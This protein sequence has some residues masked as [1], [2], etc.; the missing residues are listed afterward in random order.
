ML[1]LAAIGWRLCVIIRADL[2]MTINNFSAILSAPKVK[3][4]TSTSGDDPSD[5]YA[6]KVFEHLEAEHLGQGVAMK[7]R[8]R[9]LAVGRNTR[10]K[11][12]SKSGGYLIIDGEADLM[13]SS[14]SNAK[15]LVADPTF[16]IVEVQAEFEPKVE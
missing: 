11:M 3:I 15:L 8:A 2:G 14:Y 6:F 5:D 1:T 7:A 4:W 16:A 10:P 9:Q 13:L 12:P